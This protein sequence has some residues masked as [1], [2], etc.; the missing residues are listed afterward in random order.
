MG[1]QTRTPAGV[2]PRTASPLPTVA[3]HGGRLRGG[4]PRTRGLRVLWESVRS[5]AQ[6]IETKEANICPKH[7]VDEAFRM[8]ILKRMSKLGC[9]PSRC[10]R[11]A[12]EEEYADE[13]VQKNASREERGG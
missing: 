12:R 6:P 4:R 13:R 7:G 5:N 9:Q 11:P 1:R 10:V 2:S 8:N 3:D